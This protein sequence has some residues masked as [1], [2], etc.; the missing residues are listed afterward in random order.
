MIAWA[1]VGFDGGS[2]FF[3]HCVYHSQASAIRVATRL[4]NQT[5]Y[6]TYEVRATKI[7]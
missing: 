1:V 6:Y 3:V 2:D 4:N 7:R 5:S